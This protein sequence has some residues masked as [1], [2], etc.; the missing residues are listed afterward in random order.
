MKN[1]GSIHYKVAV[2]LIFLMLLV[3]VLLLASAYDAGAQGEIPPVEV[4]DAEDVGLL[5]G[6]YKII[7]MN[8]SKDD[9]E[10]QYLK[11]GNP[12]YPWHC[13]LIAKGHCTDSLLLAPNLEDIYVLIGNQKWGPEKG[14]TQEIRWDVTLIMTCDAF[15]PFFY[16]VPE[17]PVCCTTCRNCYEIGYKSGG[18][19]V[20]E[21]DLGCVAFGEGTPTSYQGKPIQL[22]AP[23]ELKA[24]RVCENKQP[25][26]KV[27]L[28]Q[29]LSNGWVFVADISGRYADDSGTVD[30]ADIKYLTNLW[31]ESFRYY[32]DTCPCLTDILL[33]DPG[34]KVITDGH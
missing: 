14:N 11:D 18:K 26:M 10:L 4:T 20:K 33:T 7:W 29:Q 13:H 32:D 17:K 25:A 31:R 1:E 2:V 6:R 12:S 34:E 19:W 30:C 21:K 9:F 5:S 28:D 27:W 24:T 8:D 16:K 15:V 22:Y 3:F 23:Q